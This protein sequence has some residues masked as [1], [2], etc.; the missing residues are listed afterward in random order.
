MPPSQWA[1]QPEALTTGVS[2]ARPSSTFLPPRTQPAR[3]RYLRSLLQIAY[4]DQKFG[5]DQWKSFIPRL[6]AA[7]ASAGVQGFTMDG[8]TGSS[9]NS[10]RL[11]TWTKETLGVEK[12]NELAEALFKR[13]F[14][15]G[16]PMCDI[17]VLTDAA[18]EVGIAGARAFLESN[19]FTDEVNEELK[20][21]RMRGISGVPHF[22]I[23]CG[24]KEVEIGGAQPP[25]ALARAI[26]SV[27][28]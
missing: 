22:I 7:F 12:Q 11:L 21:G 4:Y 27:T 10:H 6:E 8:K 5:K 3:S 13:Y 9:F 14:L 28:A 1:A 23:S 16:L 2:K 19:A 26:E 18:D 25:Q 24:D 20:Y 17:N 15:R